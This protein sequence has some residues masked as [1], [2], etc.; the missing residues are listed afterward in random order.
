MI[1]HGEEH[2]VDFERL[3]TAMKAK[4]LIM[5]DGAFCHYHIRRDGQLTIHIL[6]SGA[7]G[8][9]QALLDILKQAP[10]DFIIAKCPADL[11]SNAWYAK[12]G[13]ELIGTQTSKTNRLINIWRLDK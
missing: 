6:L 1:R 13:F 5:L 3:Y 2:G 9:G 10:A 11:E 8:G 12:R 7:P 4:S